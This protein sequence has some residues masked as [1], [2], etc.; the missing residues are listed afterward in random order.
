[1]CGRFTQHSGAKRYAKLFGIEEPKG[2]LK[3]RFNIAPTQT[4]WAC[5][6]SRRDGQRHLEILR[7]GL[8]PHWSQGPDPRYPMINA[9]AETVATKPA[10]RD[11]FRHRRCLIP[12]DGF[13][14]WRRQDGRQ[15]FYIHRADEEPLVFAG[16]WDYWRGPS[17][18]GI[19]SCTIVTTDANAVVSPIHDRMPVILDPADFQRWLDPA[20]PNPLEL[21]LLLKPCPSDGLE[22]YPV[23]RLVNDPRNE[24]E[25]LIARLDVD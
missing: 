22:A 14:E 10:Y 8:V 20:Y 2:Q 5:A 13:Y 6:I 4:A 3:S 7:F 17:G 23:S 18:E 25:D 21:Q 24:G 15:P 9:R 1:M 16:L 11:S 19:P 12:A